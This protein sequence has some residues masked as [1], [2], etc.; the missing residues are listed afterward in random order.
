MPELQ[1][2][3]D[4]IVEEAVRKIRDKPSVTATEADI[5]D[6][7]ERAVD[8]LVDQPLQTF[9]PLL[10]ENEVLSELYAEGGA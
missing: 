6:R 2:H 8:S 4:E 9:T 10:A 1:S 5:R 3:R 7:T